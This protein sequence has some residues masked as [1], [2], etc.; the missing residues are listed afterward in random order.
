[1]S[2]ST[3]AT[4]ERATELVR[5]GQSAA[6]VQLLE[7]ALGQ[8]KASCSDDSAEVMRASGE[9]ASVLFFLKEDERAAELLDGVT[10]S[11]KDDLNDEKYR[12]TLLMNLA[13]AL[14]RSGSW[15][16]AEDACRRGLQGR[17][18]VYGPD[19]AGY[20]FGL[21]PLAQVLLKQEKL[22]EA[23]QCVLEAIANFKH[24]AHPWLHST[25][26]LA[27]EIDAA[28]GKMSSS[29]W[30]GMDNAEL[31]AVA[32][33]VFS[34]APGMDPRHGSP[35]L[36]GLSDALEARKG[37]ADALL[38]EALTLLANLE[39]AGGEVELRETIL[40]RLFR[41]HEAAR[42]MKSAL[43]AQIGLALCAHERGDLQHAQNQLQ[44]AREKAASLDAESRG[45]IRQAEGFLSAPVKN[46]PIDPAL[47]EKAAEALRAQVAS[48]FGDDLIQELH[49]HFSED[50]GGLSVD[51]A[52]QREPSELEKSQLDRAVAEARREVFGRLVRGE[53]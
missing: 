42:D 33:E 40:E 25:M 43:Q 6:G 13:E 24:H 51:V 10:Q 32:K 9:L 5:S 20:A 22:D 39:A 52:L 4:L 50:E 46:Q 17:H 47:I 36:L 48:R 37:N 23:R 2:K 3:S 15:V 44:A 28:M 8:A 35:L 31:E 1:M 11:P 49:V 34:R 45:W 21:V 7:N 14:E 19:H 29:W 38:R 30:E 41:A 27:A 53:L 12:L 16:L 18:A 26:A